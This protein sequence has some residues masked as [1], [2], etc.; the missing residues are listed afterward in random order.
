MTEKLCTL[1]YIA[2]SDPGVPPPRDAN[3]VAVESSRWNA[4]D[5][6]CRGAVS[7]SRSMDVD[8]GAVLAEAPTALNTS[9]FD[10]SDELSR[11]VLDAH[12]DGACRGRSIGSE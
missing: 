12:L 2:E 7:I 8:G 6:G 5:P 1:E 4:A 3:P 10:Q 11:T 9:E